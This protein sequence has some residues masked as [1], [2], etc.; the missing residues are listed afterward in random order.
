MTKQVRPAGLGGSVRDT[1]AAELRFAQASAARGDTV[2]AAYSLGVARGYV[3]QL[4]DGNVEEWLTWHRW[5]ADC[6]RVLW[7]RCEAPRVGRHGNHLRAV[8]VLA[9]LD[10]HFAGIT[11]LGFE[12]SDDLQAI[13]D[14]ARAVV[15]SATRSR[16][17]MFP[18]E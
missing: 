10:K 6:Y 9:R 3:D 12:L 17:D 14:S 8:K 2:A 18:I 15:R 5:V 1:I 4:L 11:D 7:S 16:Y 13:V